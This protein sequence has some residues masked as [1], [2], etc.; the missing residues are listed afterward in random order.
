MLISDI[1]IRRPVFT[2]MVIVALMVLGLIGATSLGVDFFPDVDLPIAT[3]ATVYPGAGPEEVEQLV[4]K[5]LEE[6]IS[7]INGVKEMHSYSR[8]SVS[9]LIVLF[10]HDTD[11]DKALTEVREKVAGVRL[12]LPKEVED[13]VVQR[14]DPT[15]VPVL[16]YAVSS[17]RGPAET[18][19]LVDEVMKPR[20]EAVEGVATVEVLGGL[21]REVHVYVDRARLEALGLSLAQIGQQ[22]GQDSWDVPGGRITEGGAE[23]NVRTLGRFRS[24]EELS[25]V[26]VAS[27]ANGSQV[28][29][30]EVA[31][32]EDGFKEVRV[33]PLLDGRPAVTFE[34]QKA[35][36]AN[37]V[38]VA[39]GVYGVID[40]LK[41][42][43]P[44]D[45]EVTSVVD[46]S[47]FV[48]RN[49]A[50]VTEA[51]V[52]G[53][54]MAVL[55]IFVF[56]LDWR[57]TLISS[58][59][60]PTSV[61]TT[62]F[63]MWWFG[64]TFNML[65][66]MALSLA[67]GLLIDDA[68]VVRESI[69][70]HMERGED[71]V[72]AAR[73]GTNEI[74]LAVMATTFTIVAVFVP[75]AFIGGMA[76]AFFRPFG[77][78]VAAAVLVSLFISF[79]LDPMLSAR[80]FKPIEPGHHDRLARHRF[81]GPLVRGFDAMNAYYRGLLAWA[82]A[83]KKKV[84]GGAVLILVGSLALVPLMGLE[85]IP[86]GDRGEF[87][88][89]LEAPAETSI[90]A[91]E[92]LVRQAEALIR[93]NPEVR[94]IYSVAGVGEVA[95]EARLRVYTSK[96]DERAVGQSEIQEDVRQRLATIPSL[97]SRVNDI[98]FLEQAGMDNPITLSIRG[99]EY[100]TLQRL[101][102]QALELVRA[103]P[104][105]KDAD[106]SYRP[107]KPE[108]SIHVQRSRA[109]DLG[110]SVGVVAQTVRLAVE[111]EVVA[112]YRHQGRDWDVRL[113]LAP[114]DRSA[115]SM[116]AELTVPATLGRRGGG[117]A[118]GDLTQTLA[119]LASMLSGPRLVRLGEI[120]DIERSSGPATIERYDR[121][122][123]ITISANLAG[124][125]L[126]EA[127]AEI[128][129]GLAKIDTP[130]GYRFD[131]LGE[132]Q[133]MR[134]ILGDMLLALLVA[135]LFIYFVLASQFESFIHPFTIMIALPLAL[136]GA[137]LALFLSGHPNS[138]VTMIGVVLLMGLV[139]KNSIL[140]VD[141]TN[142][143]REQ[144]RSITEALLEAGPTRLRPILMTSAAMVLGMLP[145][146]LLRGEG[147]EIRV[148][149][150]IA[151]IGGVITSTFLTLLVVPVVYT[152]M[153]RFS[154]KSR[155]RM[156]VGAIVAANP[157]LEEESV[158]AVQNVS[159]NRE[160]MARG[161]A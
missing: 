127:V 76:G 83:H 137:M 138:I 97:V 114:E 128:E 68:V 136:V 18:R 69:F 64:F 21:E 152:W 122:R 35:G 150:A 107:G 79:T 130:A 116:L 93:Q 19:R 87:M 22:L 32:V 10:E 99:E 12:K 149:M 65:T 15:V 133:T 84:V 72:T 139:T 120:A 141:L 33:R 42:Q 89:D 148:G 96:K 67:I 29:L 60:L 117:A 159:T 13:S 121:Q 119:S 113:Q 140:L 103:T 16:T 153:D 55:V 106:T 46:G 56:M 39:D 156:P 105:V 132:T 3:V 147:S 112:K 24:I 40:E 61:V 143:L 71:R 115:S 104:G 48:R 9:T 158:T 49:V 154:L 6:A 26:V 37:A 146:A 144:G 77:L 62:F 88:V 58:L 111:G 160:P 27:L 11:A 59:A 47:L 86:S 124:R 34:I 157:R 75:V 36:G 102:N 125:S 126:G 38:A 123:Q 51:I 98:P 23:L 108:T 2:V 110:V 94:R 135:V 131:F 44:G 78:T 66:L 91:M 14:H 155:M 17:D 81:F 43:L 151:V 1:A 8:D 142:A 100:A 31:R 134:E 145:A 82:L 109:A 7:A 101:S 30:G 70:R 54:L 45:V 85:F 73:N 53:G 25:N 92:G 50:D 80:V 5:E 161:D 118:G 28:R 74:G 20:L 4:T 90:D 57:S 52:F 41:A 129:Q 63:A 95:N